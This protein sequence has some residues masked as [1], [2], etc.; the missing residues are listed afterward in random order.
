MNKQTAIIC[1]LVSLLLISISQA[2]KYKIELNKTQHDL[3]VVL[4]Y[5]RQVGDYFNIGITSDYKFHIP[6]NWQTKD[7][8]A[9]IPEPMNETEMR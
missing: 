4:N 6:R 5:Y 7:F 2:V 8:P 9:K 3:K 1:I